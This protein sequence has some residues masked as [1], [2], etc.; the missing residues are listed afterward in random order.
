[1]IQ[2]YNQYQKSMNLLR[3]LKV[4]YRLLERKMRIKPARA[5]D[6]QRYEEL[7]EI[8]SELEAQ[9]NHFDKLQR[10]AI[11]LDFESIHQT[12][13]LLIV[14][15]I[16]TGLSQ[17]RFAERVGMNRQQLVNYEKTL[18]ESASL[19]QIRK[20]TREIELAIAERQ[21]WQGLRL[22]KDCD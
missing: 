5:R 15:R 2:N 12:G 18:Y 1:M 21:Y 16:S 17:A 7:A 4:N 20:I 10:G 22:I 9:T 13:T 3:Q 6:Q 8:I 11:D 19:K 14:G